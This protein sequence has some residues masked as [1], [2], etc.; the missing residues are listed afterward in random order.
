MNEWM[1]AIL[2]GKDEEQRWEKEK[3][4]EGIE[5]AYDNKFQIS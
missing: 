1:S 2:K 5:K 3:E 4:E